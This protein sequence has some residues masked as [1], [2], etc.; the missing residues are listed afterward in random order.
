MLNKIF[1]QENVFENVVW[2]MAAILSGPQC[3]NYNIWLQHD[4]LIINLHRPCDT[5]WCHGT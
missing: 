3:V 5:V 4:L 1:I 2:N